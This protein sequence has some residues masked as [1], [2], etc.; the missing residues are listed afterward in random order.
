ME[1]MTL[2]DPEV[3]YQNIRRAAEVHRQVRH[4]T[5]KYIRPGMSL[6]EIAEYIEN[7]TRALVEEDGL[8]CG[9]GFPTGLSLNNCAAHFTPNAGDT[10]STLINIRWPMMLMSYQYSKVVTCSRSILEFM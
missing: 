6:T 3:T 10:T 5:R 2:E 8:E 4:Y 1:K 9:V 7:G